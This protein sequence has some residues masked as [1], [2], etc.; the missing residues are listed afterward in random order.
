VNRVRTHH[1]ESYEKVFGK[2]PDLDPLP[3][4]ASPNGTAEDRAAWARLTDTQRERI[5]RVFANMG[6]SIAAF[7]RRFS[8][9]ESRF[10]RY[11]AALAAGG[12]GSEGILTSQEVRGLRLFLDEGQCATCHNGPLFTDHAFHNTG[13]PPG[14]P[15]VPDTGRAEGVQQLQ[16][17]EFNCLGRFSDAKPGECAE[18]EFLATDD[19]TQLGAFRTPSLRN[20]AERAPYMHAGQLSTLDQVIEHYARSP[21]A[22]IG[23][24][25]LARPGDRHRERQVIR[26][27]ANDVLDLKA[28]LATLTGPVLETVSKDA[29]GGAD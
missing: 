14:D 6:K 26:L 11:A 21:A 17:D 25:E 29:P 4:A 3:A 22:S 12:R 19:P 27:T 1:V 24:S 9:G 18:L 28:F 23:H 2:L 16:R 20:V 7:E 8:Y 15:N 10:D 13:V 5:N